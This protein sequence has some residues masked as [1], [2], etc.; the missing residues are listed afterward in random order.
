[1]TGPRFI[2][3]PGCGDAAL[4]RVKELETALEE[5]IERTDEELNALKTAQAIIGAH[6]ELCA[7]HAA[8]L[9]AALARAE[10]AERDA[11]FWQQ[12]AKNLGDE[13]IAAESEAASLR[14][15]HEK[16][17]RGAVEALKE[18]NAALDEVASLRAQLTE[19][20]GELAR[21]QKTRNDAHAEV[22]TLERAYQHNRV[23]LAAATELLD[24]Q[25][26]E[27]AGYW[28]RTA[29]PGRP[30]PVVVLRRMWAL[31]AS[32]LAT[33]RSDELESTEHE[34]GCRYEREFPSVDAS[35]C[36]RC[37]RTDFDETPEAPG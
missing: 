18:R 2:K 28:N 3:S 21:M 15:E 13:R 25:K 34:P 37:S 31:L 36:P 6:N 1:M 22:E 20:N 33:T 7:K 35:D 5:S 26:R 16:L 17:H 9:T 10:G 4:A 29:C 23:R 27:L 30:D 8:E 14:A 11:A 19:L 32:Q 24:G 12:A